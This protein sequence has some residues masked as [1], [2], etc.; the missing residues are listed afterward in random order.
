MEDF[1]SNCTLGQLQ[2]PLS[3]VFVPCDTGKHMAN[4]TTILRVDLHNLT[5]MQM[6]FS[7]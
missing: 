6:S 4:C 7:S 5:I 2:T 1:K 3:C